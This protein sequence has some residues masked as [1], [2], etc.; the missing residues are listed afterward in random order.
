MRDGNWKISDFGLTVEGTSQKGRPT[1]Y[2]RGTASYRAP[3]LIDSEDTDSLIFNNKSDIWAM[4]CVLHDIVF[5]KQA[6]AN[7]FKVM[8]PDWQV[9]STFELPI[10]PRS[11]FVL[12]SLLNS[13]LSRSYWERPGTKF[14]LAILSILNHDAAEVRLTNCP[15]AR[16]AP[17]RTMTAIG[18]LMANLTGTPTPR[19]GYK[20]S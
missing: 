16:E 4:G 7:D 19:D 6:F 17:I 12:Q 11:K 10:D 15:H 2:G 9:P 5:K 18:S 3:E 1:Q 13:T 8:R 14:V 20:R